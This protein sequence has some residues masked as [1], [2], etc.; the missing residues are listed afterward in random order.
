MDTNSFV[1]IF[2][3]LILSYSIYYVLY[4]FITTTI[5]YFTWKFWNF[6][7]WESRKIKLIRIVNDEDALSKDELLKEIEENESQIQ[8]TKKSSH[9]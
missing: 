5:V 7:T 2:V 3:S 4:I 8:E 6:A 9:P 1:K